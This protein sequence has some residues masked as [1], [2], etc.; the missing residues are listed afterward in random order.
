LLIKYHWNKSV[1]LLLVYY[2]NENSYFLLIKI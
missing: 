1:G 2:E